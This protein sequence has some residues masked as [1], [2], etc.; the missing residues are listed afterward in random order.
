MFYT[1]RFLIY[2]KPDP[3]YDRIRTT[4][5][6]SYPN[7]SVLVQPS[8]GV[9]QTVGNE[10]E[11]EQSDRGDQ[12]KNLAYDRFPFD[13]S[14]LSTL[15]GPGSVQTDTVPT[16][17]AQSR[18]HAPIRYP[19]LPSWTPNYTHDSTKSDAFNELGTTGSRP[20]SATGC[21]TRRDTEDRLFDELKG[22]TCSD[23]EDLLDQTKR[24]MLPLLTERGE[25]I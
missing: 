15:L 18:L 4:T 6:A 22:G 2:S 8:S 24:R 5:N 17:R 16:A 21:N 11:R 12:G 10:S 19:T 3:V 14:S 25:W 20:M 13:M 7:G 1:C 9:D 23:V